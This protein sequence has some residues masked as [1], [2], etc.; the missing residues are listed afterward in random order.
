[1]KMLTEVGK[2]RGNVHGGERCIQPQSCV[3]EDIM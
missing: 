1:M 2:T 3:M